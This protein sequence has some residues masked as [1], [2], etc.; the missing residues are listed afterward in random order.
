MK[1]IGSILLIIST[2]AIGFYLSIMVKRRMKLFKELSLFVSNVSSSIRFSGADIATV[3]QQECINVDI[4][5]IETAIQYLKNGMSMSESW[6]TSVDNIPFAYGLSKED[7]SIIKQFGDKLGA[8]DVCGQTEHCEYFKNSFNGRAE[9]LSSQYNN[10]V[11]V[12]RS[13]GFFNG[14]ALVLVIL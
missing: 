11:K 13:L 10:K 8:T 6:S 12:Y 3:L 4:P 9:L 14:L 2:T 5:F 7:K 1:A